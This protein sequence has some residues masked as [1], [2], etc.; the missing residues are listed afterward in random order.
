[1]TSR[2][3]AAGGVAAARHADARGFHSV[4]T[5]EFFN[6]HGFVRLAACAALDSNR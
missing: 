3:R 1:M 6:Q 2:A 4:W 5:V